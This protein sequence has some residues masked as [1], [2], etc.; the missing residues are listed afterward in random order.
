MAT[1]NEREAKAAMGRFDEWERHHFV[2]VI[3]GGLAWVLGVI[4]IIL[5]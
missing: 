5:F 4:A 1:L 3:A 2:R